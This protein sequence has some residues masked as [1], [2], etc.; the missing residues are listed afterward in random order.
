[1][2][3]AGAALGAYR[4]REALE[5]GAGRTKRPAR[6][7]GCLRRSEALL[8]RRP[9]ARPAQRSPKFAQVL[10][11]SLKFAARRP[12]SLSA[13][14]RPSAW[15]RRAQATTLSARRHH[16]FIGR[17]IKLEHA[18]PTHFR[19]PLRPS[20]VA[21]MLQQHPYVTSVPARPLQQSSPSD[22]SMSSA[23]PPQQVSR[24]SP[25]STALVMSSSNIHAK[26]N[27]RQL[28][29]N[30]SENSNNGT[31][32]STNSAA[33][34]MQPPNPM[35]R[36]FT[37]HTKSMSAGVVVPVPGI[38]NNLATSIGLSHNNAGQPAGAPVHQT[39]RPTM[40][41]PQPGPRNFHPQ[42]IK[43]HRGRQ[44]QQL[45][46]QA[47]PAHYAHQLPNTIM[48]AASNHN[49]ANQPTRANHNNG[50]SMLLSNNNINAVHHRSASTHLSS[51][52][53]GPQ[54]NHHS[55]THANSN[56]NNSSR[57]HTNVNHT[58][59]RNFSSHV[60]S[61]IL[62]I[63]ENLH[64]SHGKLTSSGLI[65]YPFNPSVTDM[66]CDN[67]SNTSRLAD[68]GPAPSYYLHARNDIPPSQAVPACTRPKTPEFLPVCDLMFNLISMI[69]YFCENTFGI[70]ALVA[71]Y[72]H[73]SNQLWSLIGFV[74]VIAAN[75]IGQY[76]SFKW[77]FKV[78]LEECKR[79][80]EAQEEL[81][82][83][84]GCDGRFYNRMGTNMR[85]YPCTS[86]TWLS[87][88]ATE[89]QLKFL[90][91]I[92]IDALLHILCLGTIIR[93]IKLVIPVNDTGRVKR[94]ARDLCML[95]IIHGFVQ[96]APLMLLQ[97]YMI[98][99]QTSFGSITNLS[100][101]SAILSLLNVCWALASFTKYTR[102]KFMHKFVLTWLGIISQ[103]LWRLCTVSSRVAALTI[104]AVY[105]N[106]WMLVV[107]VMHWVTMFLWLIKPGNLLRDE[108]NLSRTRK[109][110]MAMGVAWIYCFCYVNFE[111]HNSKLKMTSYYLITF[112]EN[113]LL[114][115]VCLIFSSQVTWFKNIS[116]L[117]VYLGFVFGIMFLVVYYK[118]FHVNVLS[119]GISCSQ[120]S[121]DSIADQL[122][123]AG[124]KITGFKPGTLRL[125]SEDTLTTTSRYNGTVGAPFLSG[126]HPEMAH[127]LR[128]HYLSGHACKVQNMNK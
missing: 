14:T 40:Q 92:V 18:E 93:Y 91:S 108:V 41:H 16:N 85:N 50:F 25:A 95:R 27:S 35:M 46:G 26:S 30:S 48:H 45:A 60:T 83:E 98:C 84:E 69:M 68:G 43:E 78:K 63:D 5:C 33:H 90:V 115:T 29:P 80:R 15:N 112:L 36:H 114:L 105:Y 128:H 52:M 55:S 64:K 42:V 124:K 34:P 28:T 100:V 87:D 116:I 117:V 67:V 59:S 122:S 109:I 94:G 77:L 57:N 111:E 96:S 17:K 89:V 113:N 39:G 2:A 82:Q 37:C 8:A 10:P 58:S 62:S 120:D 24:A 81:E 66:S 47:T 65:P 51:I 53:L 70:I 21:K 19:S 75:L 12:S 76:L 79:K 119:D 101:T 103:L 61:S 102:Q 127:T 118:Y 86:G 99:S 121:I 23:T 125:K 71:L 44:H 126:S 3:S 88:S 32:S 110:T 7:A 72:Y 106:Y 123:P 54:H 1:M 97:S 73:A 49:L 104:Y 107:L 11:S 20:E 6:N 38:S 22:Q 9:R 4:T 13:R 56:N 31:S 74:F